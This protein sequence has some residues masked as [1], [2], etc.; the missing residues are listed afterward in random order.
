MLTVRA[1]CSTTG[2]GDLRFI[3]GTAREA[4]LLRRT[5]GA[6]S[7]GLRYQLLSE[8]EQRTE[9]RG[10]ISRDR[11]RGSACPEGIVRRFWRFAVGLM[12]ITLSMLPAV[13][14]EAAA[15]PPADRPL[16]PEAQPAAPAVRLVTVPLPFTGT[17]DDP[18]IDRVRGAVEQLPQGTATRP[19][20]ILEFLAAEGTA[21][22]GTEFESAL[23]LARALT[24]E[25]LSGVRTVAFLPRSVKGHAVLPVI[26]CDEIIMA[27]QAEFGAAGMEEEAI[28]PLLRASY[29]EIA[30]RR[31]TVP[32]SVAL[33]LLDRNLKLLKVQTIDGA[34]V[35]MESELAELEKSTTVSAVDTLKP[36][37]ELA[38]FTGA[39]WRHELGYVSHLANDRKEVAEAL[40]IPL[41]S[42][43][44][45]P[46]VRGKPQAVRINL[47]GPITD[48]LVDRTLKILKDQAE[49]DDINLIFL[50]IRSEG[51]SL[52]GALELAEFLTLRID[53]QRVRTVAYVSDQ[54]FGAAAVVALGADEL[55]VEENAMLGGQGAMSLSEKDFELAIPR[56]R[57][58]MAVR[59][60]TWSPALALAGRDEPLRMYTHV[61]SGQKQLMGELEYNE[62]KDRNDWSPGTD[63]LAHP[64]GIDADAAVNYELAA[65]RTR[66]F[67]EVKTIYRIEGSIATARV[68]WALALIERL[69]DRH[70]SAVLLFIGTFA[71]FSELSSPGLGIPGFIAGV[72]FLLFF[73]ANFLHGNADL[74]EFLLFAAGMMCI[75]IEIFIAPG[76]MVFGIG[77]ALMVVVSIVLASQTFVFP[78]NAYQL[79]QLPGSLL[80]VAGA[81]AGGLIGVVVLQ[82]Y[83][84]HTPY[85]KRLILEPPV[86]APRSDSAH[87]EWFASH[88]YLLGKQGVAL[89]PLVPAG[90][91]RF[92]DTLVDVISEGPLVEAG[93][94]ITVIEAVGNRI[95]VR[96]ITA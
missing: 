61:A 80:M 1:S 27:G 23:K 2:E 6:L 33:A 50:W 90:K 69:A 46:L 73:W 62:R 29:E 42:L 35:I 57:S 89:T 96:A 39:T 70:V 38:S 17:D 53:R 88:E 63:A 32:K 7:L 83:L 18:V 64:Q 72:C 51:G 26:A 41:A 76:T 22:E 49:R 48:R 65:H 52:D 74:L 92:G 95:R 85:L 31:R 91:A 77:G 30:D 16:R 8:I 56:I 28:G 79:Q 44:D 75:L 34:R 78:T 20:L 43:D 25:Q 66:H 9:H 55:I 10:M 37:G 19:L 87:G 5:S 71:L 36:E 11:R 86:E 93:S 60:R 67:D 47:D 82:R 12:L 68:N 3:E 4:V 13:G 14:Q 84:P 21:G 40:Q 94:E 54:A 59:D 15:P 24:G 58:L 45:N 81:A